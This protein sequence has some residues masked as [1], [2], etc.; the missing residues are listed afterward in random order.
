MDDQRNDRDGSIADEMFVYDQPFNAVTLLPI[1]QPTTAQIKLLREI[2][3]NLGENLLALRKILQ[4]G[5]CQ[6]FGLLL[7]EQ[8]SE[9]SEKLN[10][11]GIPHRI[12]KMQEKRILSARKK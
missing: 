1:E 8:A 2:K 7:S 5:G 10:E 11:V 9:L 3:A 6:M 4:D 12:D